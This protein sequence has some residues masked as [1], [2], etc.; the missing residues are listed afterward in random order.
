MNDEVPEE[1]RK[2]LDQKIREYNM[3]GV[4][5]FEGFSPVQM[6]YVLY[7][8][9][10]H[11]CPVQFNKL[12]DED[13]DKIPLFKQV[14][15]LASLINEKKVVKLTD[16][17]FLPVKI[18]ED[19]HSR[20]YLD[21]YSLHYGYKVYKETDSHPIHLAR[22]LIELGGIARKAK[23][24]LQLTVKGKKLMDDKNA[25]LM[26]LLETYTAKYKWAYPDGYEDNMTGQIGWAFSLVLLSK[27]GDKTR[28]VLYYS[29]KYF[30]A[31]P[32]LMKDPGA[33]AVR[34]FDRFLAYFGLAEV[35][36]TD[37]LYRSDATVKKTELL[38]RF[39]RIQGK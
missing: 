25:F 20:N 34:V 16:K 30:K 35:K 22:I 18:V 26:K 24:E 39:I 12:S 31:L 13:L 14:Y 19:M 1:L 27:Y 4:K 36:V 11:N 17:G 8:P 15:Y 37:G 28:P 38:D 29:D 21:D 9:F 32:T 10:D 6:G 2:L 7:Q 23:K 5:D 3:A 33:Y